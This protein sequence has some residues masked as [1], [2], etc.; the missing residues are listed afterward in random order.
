[1]PILSKRITGA[2]ESSLLAEIPCW[3]SWQPDGWLVRLGPADQL[4]SIHRS[5]LPARY[6]SRGVH[7]LR[8][9][10]KMRVYL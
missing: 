3:T 1:M 9:Y 7:R 8:K 6:S 4:P 5:E 10:R 2:R